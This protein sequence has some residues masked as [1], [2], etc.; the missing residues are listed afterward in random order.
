MSTSQVH[1]PLRLTVSKR[2]NATPQA[3]FAA[4]TDPASLKQWLCPEGGSVSFAAA[5]VQV[6]GAYRIDMQFGQQVVT[7]HGVYQEIVPP[8]KLV[9]TWE[10][11][12][13]QGQQTVVTVELFARG[14]ETELV[15]TH[16][17]FPSAEATQ[18]HVQG[19]QSILA[20]LDQFLAR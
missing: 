17:R 12:N 19:W 3:I 16:E 18:G 9:F 15:L 14:N 13:T 5:D 10:S 6:G 8:S 20:G 7:H 4:W 1:S 11:A 2:Y